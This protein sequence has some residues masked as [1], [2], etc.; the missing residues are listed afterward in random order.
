MQTQSQKS[1]EVKSME[2]SG[3]M[4]TCIQNCLD[5]YKICSQLLSHCLEKGGKHADPQHIKLLLD[6][7]T[8]CEVSADFMLRNSDRHSSICEVCAEICIACAESCEAIADDAMMKKCV[9]A[10]RKC[11]SSCEQMAHSKH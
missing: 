3:E 10:C 7:A 8:I 1:T 5:G 2:M 11:A 9:D 4:E 6:C